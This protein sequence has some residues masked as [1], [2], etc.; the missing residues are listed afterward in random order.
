MLDKDRIEEESELRFKDQYYDFSSLTFKGI[1]WLP[2]NDEKVYGT[3]EITRGDETYLNLMGSFRNERDKEKHSDIILGLSS[4]GKKITLY[5]CIERYHSN[6]MHGFETSIYHIQVSFIGEHF[7]GPEDILFE[8]VKIRFPYLDEWINHNFYTG[9]FN[10]S[11]EFILKY[12]MPPVMKF[13]VK[14]EF[15]LSIEFDIIRPQWFKMIR[16]PYMKHMSFVILNF[17]FAKSFNEIIEIINH[18][19]Y[20][21]SFAINRPIT[22]IVLQG[23]VAKKEGEESIKELITVFNETKNIPIKIENILHFDMFFLFDEVSINFEEIL[24]NWIE[25]GEILESVYDLYFSTIY[26][27]GM[28]LRYKFLSRIYALEIYHRNRKR[29]Y[30]LDSYEHEN[31][32]SE[33]MGNIP[34]KHKEWLRNKLLYSN[35]PTLRKRITELIEDNYFIL[36]EVI[37]EKEKF[38]Q[39]LII[40]RNYFVHYN[41]Q[42]KN[43]S[44]K[45]VELSLLSGTQIE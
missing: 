26:Q 30:E 2:G 13:L 24:N 3:L 20:F 4:D 31:R 43:Q 36:K 39:K 28:R 40:T 14:N 5:R 16:E 37:E 22:P 18:I 21:L 34:E 35:E 38:I 15:N 12:N 44:A 17:S 8:K 41:E 27:P 1:W 32:I 45:E 19:Q 23:I 7:S 33:I 11:N 10:E 25:K 9:E 6:S 42:L 29:N